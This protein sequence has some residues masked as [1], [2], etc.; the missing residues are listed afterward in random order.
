MFTTISFPPLHMRVLSLNKSYGNMSRDSGVHQD[1]AYPEFPCLFIVFMTQINKQDA[2]VSQVYYLTFMCGSTCFGRLS[3]HH[4]E[5]TTALGASGVIVGEKRLERCW[6]WSA[7][8]RP[9]TLQPP[10]SNGKTRG[11]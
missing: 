3:A 10:R 6:S 1:I 11:S 4:Q 2:T 8:P 9:T 5:H 7:R